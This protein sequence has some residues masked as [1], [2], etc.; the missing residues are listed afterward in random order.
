M[1]S[2]GALAA[3][4]GIY[5]AGR[6]SFTTT[7]TTR[8]A[9]GE[10]VVFSGGTLE[11]GT[12][13]EPIHD[14]ASAEIVIRDGLLST[15]DPGQHLEGVVVVNGTIRVHGRPLLQAFLRLAAAPAAGATTVSAS[16]SAVAAGWQAGDTVL[17]PRSSQCRVASGACA[18][19]ETETRD[20]QSMSADGRQLTLNLP[21]TVAHP[22]GRRLDGTVDLLPHVLNLRRNVTIRSENPSGVRG[23][24]LVHGSYVTNCGSATTIARQD[25]TAPTCT[26][27]RDTNQHRGAIPR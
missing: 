8:L 27:S 4:V 22:G 12:A 6:L 14:E 21:F 15:A 18:D 20:V 13:S 25:R 19:N 5:P 11:L 24:V 16:T 3:S 7:A 23:H 26:S 2:T 10:V 1:T 17:V 9:T